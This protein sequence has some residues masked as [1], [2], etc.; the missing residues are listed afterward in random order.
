MDPTLSEIRIFAGNFAPLS[1]AFCN[2]ALMSIAENT[3]LFSLLGT[4]YGGDGQT[5]FALPDLR[6]RVPVG[7]GQ[8][9][10]LSFWD[11]GEVEGSEGVT[12]ILSQLAA[13][14]HTATASISQKANI[15]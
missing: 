5:T 10:G 13:H 11:L 6:G 9:A 15:G 8:G 14:N 2:G 1:W 12:L 7:T 4:T 3:A